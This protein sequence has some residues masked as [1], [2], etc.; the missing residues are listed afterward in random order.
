[1]PSTALSRQQIAKF[2]KMKNM[3]TLLHN[4]TFWFIAAPVIILGLLVVNLPGVLNALGLNRPYPGSSFNLSGKRA[5]I[6]ATNHDTLGESGKKTGVYASEMTVPYYQFLDGTMQVDVASIQGGEIPVEPVSLRWPILTP[7]DKRFQSDG[8]FQE[9]VKHSL[10]IADLDFTQYD[11]VFMAGGWGAAYDLGYSEV[12]G[13]KISAAYAADVV[14]G[15]V[16]HGALGFLLAKDR[17]GKPL[18]QGRRMTAVT[19]KQVQELGITITPQHPERELRAA[20]VL[21]ESETAFLDI[22]ASHVVVDGTLVTGQNQNDGAEVAQR[23]M[24]IIEKRN[25]K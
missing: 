18:V 4:R 6:I 15:S 2:K 21:Y 11:I 19:N 23:M 24:D 22:F 25:S 1:M 10:K 12:L 13:Q 7:E 14:L 8:E 16:C 17:N 3:Q 5:L 9:K 20:G